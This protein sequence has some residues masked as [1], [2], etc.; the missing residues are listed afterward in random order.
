MRAPRASLIQS[1]VDPQQPIFGFDAGPVVAE[2]GGWLRIMDD[3]LLPFDKVVINRVATT[4]ERPDDI[5]LD[6]RE[7][8]TGQDVAG[9][10]GLLH[11]NLRRDVGAGH[12]PARRVPRRRR[13]LQSGHRRQED[14]KGCRCRVRTPP[15]SPT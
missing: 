6:L 12:R 11:R 15:R 9:R 8:K 10:Q 14:S 2:G 3:N 5:F 1:G 4:Q 7:A 13:R